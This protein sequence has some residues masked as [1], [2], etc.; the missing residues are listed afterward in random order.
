LELLDEAVKSRFVEM[1]GRLPQST[2]LKRYI[3]E[4]RAGKSLAGKEKCKNKVLKTGAATFGFFDEN[5]YKYLPKDYKPNSNH[6]V[7]NGDVI[8]FG[9]DGNITYD[10]ILEEVDGQITLV[11]YVKGTYVAPPS[12]TITFQPINR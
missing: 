1:F 7:E 10:L 8:S 6:L 11:P 2:T 3:I 4:L 12:T 5:Q 9:I